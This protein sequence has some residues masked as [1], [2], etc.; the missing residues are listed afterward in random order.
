MIRLLILTKIM[1]LNNWV[2]VF[3]LDDT[4]YSE[5][6]YFLSG[7]SSVEQFITKSFNI[8]FDG[9]IRKA[10]ENGI[11]DL[12]GWCCERLGLPLEIKESLLWV[13]RL[14]NPKIKLNSDI[15]KLIDTL[16][17]NNATLVILTDGRSLTQRLKINALNLQSLPLFISEE[18]CSLKP[19][20]L[21]FQEIEKKWKG[22]KYVYIGDNPLKDFNAPMKLGW[23]CIG[24]DWFK[25]KIHQNN[26]DENV[27]IPEYWIKNPLKILKILE[28]RC[29]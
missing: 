29:N 21:R 2:I 25:D 6:S 22:Y 24:A 18:Y 4:L 23:L 10:S 26:N 14:H 1:N 5:K 27:V 8:P 19:N 16:K 28:F 13:Y 20:L 7:L 3:D 11:N 17:K 9:E 15:K 12:W